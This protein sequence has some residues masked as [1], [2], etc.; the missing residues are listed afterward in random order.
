MIAN[1]YLCSI[2]ISRPASALLGNCRKLLCLP[3]PGG[4]VG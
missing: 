2:K 3:G 4:P 1:T